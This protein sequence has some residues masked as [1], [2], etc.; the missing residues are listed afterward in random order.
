MQRNK[1]VLIFP[2]EGDLNLNKVESITPELREII[3]EGC[4]RIVLNFKDVEYIDSMGITFLIKLVKRLREI[5]GRLSLTNVGEQVRRVLCITCLIDYMSVLEDGEV[6]I[7]ALDPSS[8]PSYRTTVAID[9]Q[10]LE[11]SRKY[12]QSLLHELP[13][14]EDDVFDVTLA[15]GEAISNAV[16]H[17]SAN[18]VYATISGYIDRV[19]VEV[20]DSGCGFDE[21]QN[22][23]TPVERGRGIKL[24]R[25]L[26]DSVTI[27]KKEVGTGTVVRL[28]KLYRNTEEGK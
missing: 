27:T 26:C 17:G 12:L 14:D 13:M 2:I 22:T 18:E 28:I 1:N 8:M 20:S 9:P 6:A 11:S 23:N 25:L 16:D 7:P 19:I 4:K 5:G 3:N 10:D 15:C 21:S 24:M